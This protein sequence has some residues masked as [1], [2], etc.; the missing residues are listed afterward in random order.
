MDADEIP[1][2]IK[3]RN[4]RI[5]RLKEIKKELAAK[6]RQ[7][8]NTTDPDAVFM[9]TRQ[10]IKTAYN[11]QIAVDESHQVIVAADVVNEEADAHQLIPM[12]EQAERVAGKIGKLSADAG[13]SSGE[14]LKAMDSKAIDAHIPDANYQGKQRGKQ[15]TPGDQYFSRDQFIRD[16]LEDCFICPAGKKLHFA[17]LQRVKNS[18]PL[19]LYK[20]K[21]HHDC[22]LRKRCTKSAKARTITLNPHGHRFGAMRLKLDSAHGKRV[23]NKRK[24]IVEPVF[25]H[26]KETIG[27]KGFS[28]RGLWKVRGEFFL[29]CIAH[30]LRK[31]VNALKVVAPAPA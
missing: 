6:G 15:K 25:G 20:C 26:I 28:L 23:Y 8:I 30:N 24:T 12:V 19:R 9:K 3:D 29:V 11:A 13:Y 31:L 27:F 1:E 5:E 4:K 10:G 2:G 17:Y 16:E 21:D 18:E 14:N 22:P 7:K